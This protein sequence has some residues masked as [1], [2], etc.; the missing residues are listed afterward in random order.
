[1]KSKELPLV[2][3]SAPTPSWSN[4]LP[5]ALTDFY[6]NTCQCPNALYWR[7][8][9]TIVQDVHWKLNLLPL[10]QLALLP[11]ISC[12]VLISYVHIHYLWSSMWMTCLHSNLHA[13]ASDGC[14]KAWTHSR[15]VGSTN[16]LVAGRGH[17]LWRLALLSQKPNSLKWSMTK[18]HRLSP[19]STSSELA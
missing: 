7:A 12:I 18:N 14:V 10:S 17:L 1:M 19:P 11:Q 16:L 13:Q 2:Q 9:L 6:R 4:L 5:D 15:I 3:P 8:S